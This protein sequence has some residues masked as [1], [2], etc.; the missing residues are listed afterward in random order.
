[1]RAAPLALLS[2]LMILPMTGNA[3]ARKR[4][5]KPPE[6]TVVPSKTGQA[7]PATNIKP[8]KKQLTVATN[9]DDDV[10]S[11]PGPIPFGP[12]IEL[13]MTRA[14]S[15][16]IDLRALP[17]TP[18]ERRDRPEREP[19]VANPTMVGGAVTPGISRPS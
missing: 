10:V 3:T 19:P 14:A 7:I 8:S 12:P 16:R 13:R 18:P 2:A 15:R 4:P 11:K 1:M 17:Q 6:E 5:P 9:S